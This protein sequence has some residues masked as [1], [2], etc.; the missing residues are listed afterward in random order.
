MQHKYKNDFLKNPYTLEKS[1]DIDHSRS[2]FGKLFKSNLKGV[3]SYPRNNQTVN[4]MRGRRR[5]VCF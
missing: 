5:I 1:P 4:F 3:F 2:P